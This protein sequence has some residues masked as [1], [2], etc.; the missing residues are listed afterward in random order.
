MAHRA[1]SVSVAFTTSLSTALKTAEGRCEGT[2]P[3]LRDCKQ[4]TLVTEAFASGIESEE[5]SLVIKWH[6]LYSWQEMLLSWTIPLLFQAVGNEQVFEPKA[7][8]PCDGLDITWSTRDGS[9]SP[10]LI[11]LSPCLAAMEMVG[12]MAASWL[13]VIWG[14]SCP[15][16]R[17]RGTAGGCKVLG[18]ILLLARPNPGLIQAAS[19]SGC[20]GLGELWNFLPR[21]SSWV[22]LTVALNILRSQ[23]NVVDDKKFVLDG[24]AK[25]G[26]ANDAKPKPFRAA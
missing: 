3:G 17:W 21:C 19:G 12:Y 25:D 18:G 22:T 4:G 20:S 15:L 6:T 2:I 24:F 8:M 16:S 9:V 1:G 14:W 10:F 13:P 11:V 7:L 26:T 5:K 23:K